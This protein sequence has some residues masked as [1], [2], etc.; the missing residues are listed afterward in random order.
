MRK[1]WSAKSPL[2]LSER[3]NSMHARRIMVKNSKTPKRGRIKPPV[4]RPANVPPSL[5]VHGN[6]K[7]AIAYAKCLEMMMTAPMAQESEIWRE[8]IIRSK[9][10]RAF[11]QTPRLLRS[12]MKRT[13]VNNENRKPNFIGNVEEGNTFFN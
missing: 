5:N 12:C 6:G 3:Q 10:A 4:P 1:S 7:I 11:L 13:G 8:T 9:P 2:G